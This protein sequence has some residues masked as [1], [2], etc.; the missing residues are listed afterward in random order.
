MRNKFLFRVSALVLAISLV[1]P[2]LA[3]G[4]ESVLDRVKNR[5][6]L[7]CGVNKEL[8]GF[9]FLSQDGKWK[10][11]DVDYGRAIAAAVLGDPDKVEF[12]PLKAADRF[13]ALQTGEIDVLIRNTTWTLTRDTDL[14]ADFAPPTFYDGQGFMLRKDLGITSLKELAGAT[15]GVTAG[16]T[17]ELNLA[18]TT[19]A[20]GI[21]VEP[22]VFA[23][24]ETLYQSYDQGR[25][26]AVTSDKSQLVS[27]RQSLKNPDDH[28]ILDVT[29]SK[30]PLGPV[31]VHGDNKW[32]DVVSWVVY[33]T[34]FA[35]EHGITQANVN[36][37]E[38]ENPEI[39]RFLG[40]D[41][42]TGMGGKLGLPKDWARQVIAAVGNYG[43][44]FERNLTPLGLPRGVNKPWTQGGLLYAIPFR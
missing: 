16:S 34:F 31:T 30:E 21:E 39:K 1:T 24:T 36:T 20:L 11:F 38:T 14:G 3:R 2:L 7:I 40:T 35:E 10:G 8:P 13:P 19:R 37:F 32:N 17:T 15:I 25:C 4:E 22:I 18:D 5:G 33:A 41:D 12:R 43:E 9:G 26:D 28:V 29:I 44:L 42:G 27:R 6:R 23:E